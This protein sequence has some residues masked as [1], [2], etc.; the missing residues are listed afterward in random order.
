MP[1]G[2]YLERRKRIRER[3]NKAL[4]TDE[5]AAPISYKKY[6]GFYLWLDHIVNI[7]RRFDKT[8]MTV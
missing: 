3:L 2:A 4:D 1:E 7:A 5:K 6:D 8:Y